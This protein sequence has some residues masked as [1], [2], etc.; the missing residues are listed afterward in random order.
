MKAMHVRV[1]AV[2]VL[3]SVVICGRAEPSKE[4]DMMDSVGALTRRLPVVENTPTSYG[5][6]GEGDWVWPGATNS[7]IV[8]GQVAM[9]INLTGGTRTIPEPSTTILV[10]LGMSVVVLLG[11]RRR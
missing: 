6:G 7:N 8:T 4:D 11:R 10:C 5:S 2:M 1:A 3:L 9:A